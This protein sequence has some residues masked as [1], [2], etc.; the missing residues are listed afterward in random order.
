MAMCQPE[1]YSSSSL[2]SERNGGDSRKSSYRSSPSFSPSSCAPKIEAVRPYFGPDSFSSSSSSSSPASSESSA[3]RENISGLGI[4]LPW[5]D[6]YHAGSLTTSH[7]DRGGE[8]G[9]S[10]MQMSPRPWRPPKVRDLHLLRHRSFSRHFM[11]GLQTPDKLASSVSTHASR[12][13]PGEGSRKSQTRRN[14]RVVQ[15]SSSSTSLYERQGR[16][17][18]RSAN[19]DKGFG[20]EDEVRDSPNQLDTGRGWKGKRRRKE[21]IEEDVGGEGIRNR[22][23]TL[24]SS[25]HGDEVFRSN[26]FTVFIKRQA[27][28]EWEEQQKQ[29]LDPS[30]GGGG[31]EHL[32]LLQGDDD[33]STQDGRADRDFLYSP[34]QKRFNWLCI[35]QGEAMQTKWKYMRVHNGG[36]YCFAGTNLDFSGLAAVCVDACGAL[37]ECEG[38]PHSSSLLSLSDAQ[39]LPQD[40]LGP[41]WR[42][43]YC[44]VSRLQQ[45]YDAFCGSPEW[46]YRFHEASEAWK[47]FRAAELD[48]AAKAVCVDD[49]HR[50]VDCLGGLPENP[51][52]VV[53]S[54][55]PQAT[56]LQIQSETCMCD[57]R[58]RPKAPYEGCQSK[59]RTGRTCMPWNTQT[60]HRHIELITESHNYCRNPDNEDEIWCYTTDPDVRYDFCDPLGIVERSV[61]PGETVD[62]IVS[63]VNVV[64]ELSVRIYKDSSGKGICGAGGMTQSTNLTFQ[65]QATHALP[66][67]SIEEGAVSRLIWRNL[68]ISNLASGTYLICACNYWY[69]GVSLWNGAACSK[70]SHFGLH[71]G[72]VSI[73]GPVYPSGGDVTVMSGESTSLTIQGVRM[74]STDSLVVIQ[75]ATARAVEC[76]APNFFAVQIELFRGGA[77]ESVP[78]FVRGIAAGER[79]Y[80]K[81]GFKNIN[82]RGTQAD[83][84]D[85]SIAFTGH[86]ALCWRSTVNGLQSFGLV[87]SLVVI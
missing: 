14:G 7:G 67:Y 82:E 22:A 21:G 48:W 52:G 70:D 34:L 40:I 69:F 49:C 44:V 23:S 60:P 86:Y 5:G 20:A 3:S 17:S 75:G 66:Q 85:F 2:L 12:R 35:E 73:V 41:A 25:I 57:E 27:Q 46:L 74:T 59:T 24:G 37:I 50:K 19:Q 62:L 61:Q 30:Q 51:V 71:L 26:G 56:L 43:T 54:E 38:V 29:H 72:S 83:T 65:D 76:V 36:Y 39:K 4:S 63:G 87:K 77:D 81:T 58:V 28:K 80:L 32:S 64:P 53:L 47:C 6:E 18:A 8:R 42:Q 13:S 78:V 45:A 10:S 16:R 15:P 1:N 11:D 84:M 9:Q 33:E 79:E 31:G 68:Q 55:K